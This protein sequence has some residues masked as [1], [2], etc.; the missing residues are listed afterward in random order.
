[1]LPR[2]GDQ[3]GLD[4]HHPEC[5]RGHEGET[6][7][8]VT[9]ADSGPGIPEPLQRR[10]FDPNFTTKTASG[11]FG[12]GLGLT[13]ASEIVQKHGG[14]IDVANAPGGGAVFRVILPV[15]EAA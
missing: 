13:I 9:I 6:A 2:G 4:E 1:M 8:W 12:L 5:L 10:I 11:S 3:P 15:A 7:V 14:R